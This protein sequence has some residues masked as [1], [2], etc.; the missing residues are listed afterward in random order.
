MRCG[1]HSDCFHGY[2]ESL[3]GVL[4]HRDFAE[5]FA[6]KNL[7]LLEVARNPRTI[8]WRSSGVCR[9]WPVWQGQLLSLSIE[10]RGTA[11]GG[12]AKS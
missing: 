2:G 9:W 11:A 8:P 12:L 6:D 4:R 10:V 7:V 5:I 1:H 3:K